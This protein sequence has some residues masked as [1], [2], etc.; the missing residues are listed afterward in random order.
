MTIKNEK[1]AP[2]FPQELLNM[3]TT[4][5]ISNVLKK[6]RESKNLTLKNV[7]EEIKIRTTFLRNIE[8]N[9]FEKLPGNVYAIGFTR[10][11]SSFLGLDENLVISALK[12]A[13]GFTEFKETDAVKDYRHKNGYKRSSIITLIS[14]LLI[15]VLWGAFSFLLNQFDAQKKVEMDQSYD[16]TLDETIPKNQDDSQKGKDVESV[17]FQ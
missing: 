6:T 3:E 7:A 8:E 16:K 17:S 10:T 1:D 12:S 5:D 11:Y 13:P 9:Q 2:L 4:A 15:A 14:A